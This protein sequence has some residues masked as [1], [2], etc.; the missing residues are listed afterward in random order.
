MLV[1][2]RMEQCMLLPIRRLQAVGS[3]KTKYKENLYE[4]REIMKYDLVAKN[5]I[6]R[7]IKKS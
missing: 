4:D 2:F 6:E 3:R 5:E 1:Q 7:R